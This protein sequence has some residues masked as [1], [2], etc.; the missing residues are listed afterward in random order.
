MLD[1][2]LVGVLEGVEAG[3]DAAV[4]RRVDQRLADLL[5]GDPRC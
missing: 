1:Q 4:G 5:D 3:G 2:D